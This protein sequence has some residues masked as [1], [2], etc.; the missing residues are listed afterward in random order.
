[1]GLTVV[2]SVSTHIVDTQEIFIACSMYYL[3]KSDSSEFYPIF[4]AFCV[5]SYI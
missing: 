2:F 4:A 5:L 3:S 1:M